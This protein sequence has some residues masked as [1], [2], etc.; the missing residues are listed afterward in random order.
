MAGVGEPALA[1]P[2]GQYRQRLSGR[3]LGPDAGPRPCP[4]RQI[5]E[6]MAATLAGEA[7]DLERVG[8][9][10]QLAVPV[11]DPGP[12][13]DDVARPHLPFAEPVGA[14]RLAVEPR[15]RR[16]EPQA[17]AEEQAKPR[18]A[19]GDVI[20]TAALAE[21]TGGLPPS[22]PDTAAE[23]DGDGWTLTGH[24]A[25]V[26]A[27]ELATR[28]LVPARTADGATTVFLVDPGAP[29]VTLERNLGPHLEPL[30]TLSLASV[31]VGP[32]DVVATIFH[33]LGFDPA[34]HLPGPGGRPFPLTDL[35]TEP[36]RELFA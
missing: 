23:R 17:F 6:A 20:L 10:P 25:L 28:I 4:E 3:E 24:K 30:S 34:S 13:G 35:G 32:G 18:H 15:Y 11:Q 27:A 33:S 7:F 2:V 5:L 12:D 36:I 19:F 21:G 1:Q 8:I 26:P 9:V 14:D 29:G 16:I 31:A 22:V